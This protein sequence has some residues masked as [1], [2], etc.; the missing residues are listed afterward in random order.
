MGVKNARA[1]PY[2]P[3]SIINISAMSFGSLGKN[4]ISSL[5]IGAKQ[6]GCYHNTGEGGVS[7]YHRKGADICYQLGTG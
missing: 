4:A 5:N 2:H 7:P 1:M 3:P 6:A